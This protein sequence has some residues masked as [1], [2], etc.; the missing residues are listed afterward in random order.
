MPV[1]PAR[2]SASHPDHRSKTMIKKASP[3]GHGIV[4]GRTRL[5][6]QQDIRAGGSRAASCGAIQLMNAV[7]LPA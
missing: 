2:G 1:V 7:I 6:V 5:A 3:R 4:R